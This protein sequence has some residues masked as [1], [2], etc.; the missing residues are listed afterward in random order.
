MNSKP[1][2]KKSS[3]IYD[4]FT[5]VTEENIDKI[6]FFYCFYYC[7][8]SFLGFFFEIRLALNFIY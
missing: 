1:V 7:F 5:F 4:L 3:K 8:L 6:N 2:L